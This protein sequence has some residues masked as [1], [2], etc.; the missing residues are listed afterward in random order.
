MRI[1]LLYVY[2]LILYKNLID[3]NYDFRV[4]GSCDGTFPTHRWKTCERFE[5]RRMY[6]ASCRKSILNLLLI[7]T[8]DMKLDIEYKWGY[9]ELEYS[10][11]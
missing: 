7:A 2:R 1:T 3:E 4:K 10:S 11:S 6:R 9:C 8:E 5:Y